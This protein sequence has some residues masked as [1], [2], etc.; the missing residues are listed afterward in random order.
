MSK[1]EVTLTIVAVVTLIALVAGATYAYFAVGTNTEGFTTQNINANAE[2]VG[3]VILTKTGNGIYLNLS[4]VNMMKQYDNEIPKDVTYYGVD[5]PTGSPVT[6][7]NKISIG[8]A[9]VLGDGYYTCTYSLTVTNVNSSA[10]NNMYTAFQN[11][12]ANG[13]KENEVEVSPSSDATTGQIVLNVG[14]TEYDFYNANIFNTKA[15]GTLEN[16]TSENAKTIE[17]YMYVKNDGNKNQNAIAGTEINIEVTV[18]SFNCTAV[19]SPAL[20]ELYFGWS[21]ESNNFDDARGV[22][23]F[24]LKKNNSFSLNYQDSHYEFSDDDIVSVCG[25][26]NGHE[27]CI[28]D[29]KTDISEKCDEV[30]GTFSNSDGVFSC[31]NGITSCEINFMGLKDVIACYDVN[32]YDH[33]GYNLSKNKA[34]CGDLNAFYSGGL[35]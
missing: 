15:T 23:N 1:K 19:E 26:I 18:D 16:I 30:G 8:T 2:S 21:N 12:K 7:M 34:A 27:F 11:W 31:S 33:C 25:L 17:A 14:G 24:A 20:S 5:T 3:N 10:A 6:T 32:T 22:Y 4:A 9:T 28:N 29:T 35:N 13:Y